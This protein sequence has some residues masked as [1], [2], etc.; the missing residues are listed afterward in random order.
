[1]QAAI[2][3]GN[4]SLLGRVP[5][6]RGH[7]SGGSSQFNSFGD[8]FARA[9]LCFEKQHAK[10]IKALQPT[11]L[12]E[13]IINPTGKG[14]KRA[15]G[16]ERLAKVRYVLDSFGLE[17]SE[18]QRQFH[19]D[20]I[21]ACAHWIFKDDLETEI[22]DLLLELGVDE[23]HSEF[24]AITPRRFGKTYSVAMFAVAMLYSIE[25][26]EQAIFSTGRR[27]S[28]KLLELVYR[29][30]CKIP[31]M[32]ESIKRHNVETIWIRGP[33]GEE[34]KLFSYPSSVRISQLMLLMFF[35]CI[36]AAAAASVIMCLFFFYHRRRQTCVLGWRWW[37]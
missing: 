7:A 36:V 14:S 26:L 22:D 8:I 29:F 30:L 13:Q 24:M 15:T 12:A 23:L 28:Q 1:M 10:L 21:G 37:K 9:H 3:R 33:D 6:M 34:R 18:M 16:R 27:A 35:M 17:R 11:S 4:T 20:M 19:D 2:S 25:G 31:G 5:N 32:R